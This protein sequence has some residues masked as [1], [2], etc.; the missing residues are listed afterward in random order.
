[1]KNYDIFSIAIQGRKSMKKNRILWLAAVLAIA[2]VIYSWKMFDKA[3]PI[4]NVRITADKHQVL[5][6]ADSLSRAGG[7]ME[8]NYRSVAAFET[9]QRFKNYMELEGGGVKA[10]Q[11]LVDEG[12][13]YPYTWT[14][15]QFNIDEVREIRYDFSPSGKLLGFDLK[16]SDSLAGPDNPDFDVYSLYLRSEARAALLPDLREYKLVEKASE[17]KESG[18][19]DH[20]FTFEHQQKSAGEARY[21]LQIGVSGNEISLVR[22]YVWIPE[23]F[24]HRYEEMRSANTTISFVGMALMILVYGFAGVG[25]SLFFMLRRNSLIWKPALNWAGLIGIL[26]FFA[27]LSTLRLA[28][29][30][31]DTSLS[32]G[33]F[34]FQQFLLAIANGLLIAVIFFFSAAAAVGLDRQAFP[35]HFRFWRLWSPTL[36]ASKEVL[37]QTVFGYLWALFM[38]GFITFFYWF[39]NHVLHWWSPAENMVDPNI[40]ALPLPWLL[41]AAQSLQAGFWE[42][43]LFRAVPLAAA[44]L[45]G[46]NF[47]NKKF[48]ILLALLLQAAVFG[49]MHANYPQQPAYA[50]IVEMLIPFMLYGLIYMKWGL[51]PV[52]ISHYV[53]DIILMAMPLFLLSAP[54]IGIHR[55]LALLAAMI[56]LLVPLYRRIRAAAWYEPGDADYNL[57]WE[58]EITSA[59]K[60]LKSERRKSTESPFAYRSFPLFAAIAVLIAGAAMWVFFN[61]FKSDVPRLNTKRSQALALAE[62]FLAETVTL[63]DSLSFK[64]YVRFEQGSSRNARFVWEKSGREG[65]RRLYEKSLPSNYFEVTFKTFEGDVNARSEQFRVLVGREEEVLAWEHKVPEQRA[66]AHLTEA[67]ARS[68]AA[69]AIEDFFGIVAGDLEEVSFEPEKLPLRS[70]WKFIYRDPDSGLREGELR[71]AVSLAGAEISGLETGLHFN[72]SWEREIKRSDTRESIFQ[73]IGGMIRFGFLIAALVMGIIAWT[74]KCFHFKAFLIVTLLFFILMLLQEVLLSNAVFAMLPSSE[75]FAN[76]VLIFIIGLILGNSVSALMYGL[77]IGYMGQLELPLERNDTEFWFKGLALGVLSAGVLSF[78]SAGFMSSTAFIAAPLHADS[79][80]PLI[81]LLSS[82][83]TDYLILLIRLLIPFIL[84]MLIER[85]GEKFRGFS[86][87]LLFLS[88]FVFAGKCPPLCWLISGGVYGS[89]MIGLYMTVL[90][91]NLLYLPFIAGFILIMDAFQL[92]LANPAPMTLP[93]A[94]CSIAVLMACVFLAVWAMYRLRMTKRKNCS[95]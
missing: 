11:S 77:P 79:R 55:F 15:R 37:R 53:Y 80:M 68:K 25:I 73:M 87:L 74:K 60:A 29:F 35:E 89:L 20:L 4:V 32:S 10:F 59:P 22:P 45:I 69:T 40:L 51:L 13:Y 88:G 48:W 90:R 65:F 23:A 61:P 31:Y 34:V 44:V 93:L 2:G 26:M 52:V 24:D 91:Y 1:L 39:T 78:S 57:A 47:R 9:D 46:K 42:E 6:C 85:R 86:L 41:P 28:W 67:Q 8:E 56:P 62:K 38:I 14:V 94:L 64:P 36:G 30:G 75:P 16:V 58:A 82:T 5:A 84:A 18:R 17:L 50:R 49:S 71:Y 81:S 92:I 21:R 19:R 54:G 12:I 3:F 27:M 72:E 95:D 33:Q 7:F 66:G 43:C 83:V 63:P 70:D 76:L